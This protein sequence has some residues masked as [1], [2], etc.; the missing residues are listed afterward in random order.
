MTAESQVIPYS[1]RAAPM[2]ALGLLLALLVAFWVVDMITHPSISICASHG[3]LLVVLGIVM[4]GIS[5]TAIK[6]GI[7]PV[8]IFLFRGSVAFYSYTAACAVLAGFLIL[9]GLY[10][11]IQECI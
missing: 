11:L 6:I 1:P 2:V 5:V 8:S 9:R 10:L 7:L 4:T 3:V